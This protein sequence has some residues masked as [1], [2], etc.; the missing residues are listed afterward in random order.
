MYLTVCFG[1]WQL[2]AGCVDLFRYRAD[3]TI[4]QN[5]ICAGVTNN[6]EGD[7]IIGYTEVLPFAD[8]IFRCSERNLCTLINI[9]HITEY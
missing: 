2:G 3:Y 1:E 7:C 4:A 5:S 6:T 8:G 9:I